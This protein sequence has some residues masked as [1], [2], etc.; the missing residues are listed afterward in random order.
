[1]KTTDLKLTRRRFLVGLA[2]SAATFALPAMAATERQTIVVL[3]NH[4]DDTFSLFEE[5]FEKAQTRYRLKFVW[6]MPPDAM[7]MLRREDS[8]T[9]DVWWQAAPHNHL[10]DLSRENIL[11]PLHIATDGLPSSIGNVPLVDEQ[12]FYRATQLTAFS[13][14]V[15]RKALKDQL[16]PWPDD[17]SVLAQPEYAGK[18]GLSDPT[19]VRFGSIVIEVALQGYGWDKGWALLSEITGNAVLLA[20]GLTDELS[21][22]RQPV[23]LAASYP[24]SSSPLPVA[25]HID[26]VPNAEQRFREPLDRV[27]PKHG[28][29]INA[30][31]IGILKRTTQLEGARAFVN[32]VLSDAGQRLLPHTDLPRLPVRPAVYQQLNEKQFNPFAAQDAGQLTYK[33]I[34]S[35]SRSALL[36]TLF[37]SMIGNH[38]ELSHQWQRLHKAEKLASPV[39]NEKVAAAR[40][41]LQ[42]VPITSVVADSE[43]IKQAFVPAR[44]KDGKNMPSEAAKKFT[45]AWIEI[46]RNN[47]AQVARL[48]DEVGV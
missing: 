33:A 19:K 28:G 8:N 34:D 1:M 9:P 15:N 47:L 44:D 48:L 14:L 29:I 46:H 35:T 43:E 16:L 17:W 27:Y 13:F 22:Y 42:Q 39:P 20:S 18:V 3:T 7:K 41:A 38:A 4:N 30:G 40:L 6:L 5:A 25:V 26:T 2:A 45:A 11:Q 23:S 10:A 32:F 36:E 24:V 37:S 21:N 12:D 31:Y